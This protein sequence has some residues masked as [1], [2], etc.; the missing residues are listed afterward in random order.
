MKRRILLHFA[1]LLHIFCMHIFA[2]PHSVAFPPH[3]PFSTAFPAASAADW[4]SG[5]RWRKR[6]RFL[7]SKSSS[8]GDWL[9]A[10]GRNAAAFCVAN[11]RLCDQ[12]PK[13]VLRRGSN[14]T[15]QRCHGTPENLGTS[16][17]RMFILKHFELQRTLK[18]RFLLSFFVD[19]S[20]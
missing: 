16:R 6:R 4:L 9:E 12:R 8:V 13:D 11:L 19:L 18:S 17:R 2:P 10:D 15:Q 5:S 20:L 1:H 14:S 7:R 3:I